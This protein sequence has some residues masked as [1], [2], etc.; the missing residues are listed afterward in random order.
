MT[1]PEAMAYAEGVELGGVDGWRLPNAYELTSIIDYDPGRPALEAGAFA[2]EL[3]E[4]NFQSFWCSTTAFPEDSEAYVFEFSNR[5]MYLA[6]KD[7]GYKP[8]YVR[9]VRSIPGARVNGDTNGDGAIDLSDVVRL[10]LFLFGGGDPPVP[11]KRAEGLPITSQCSPAPDPG[12]VECFTQ[13]ASDRAGL[14]RAFEVIRPDAARRSTWYTVDHATGLAWQYEEPLMLM[15]WEEA[16]AYCEALELGGFADWRLPN[17]KEMQSIVNHGYLRPALDTT[18]FGSE[19]LA[20]DGRDY[21]SFWS[22]TPGFTLR[23]DIGLIWRAPLDPE[24][25]N[26]VR[27]VRTLEAAP[28]E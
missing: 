24:A 19:S 10:L 6:P 18:I 26:W 12:G 22:S 1:W 17:A 15:T 2:L 4:P 5:S 21:W 9:A 7:P 27:A 8:A 13:S 16:L 20:I 25:T 14:P 11:L 23:Q 3:P 28:A